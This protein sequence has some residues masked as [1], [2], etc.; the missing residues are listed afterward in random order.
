[1]RVSWILK[2]LAMLLFV[3]ST[4]RNLLRIWCN[5][6]QK[7]CY[8][9]YIDPTWHLALWVHAPSWM[10]SRLSQVCILCSIP[11]IVLWIQ[12]WWTCQ[13]P[14][15]WST[16]KDWGR[17]SS[18]RCV[19]KRSIRPQNVTWWIELIT[20]PLHSLD[21]SSLSCSSRTRKTE[22]RLIHSSACKKSFLYIANQVGVIVVR[23]SYANIL[24]NGR[25]G[26]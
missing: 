18:I 16:S 7:L 25:W 8:D 1:M 13:M 21:Y 4:V 24:I 6:P 19:Q 15:R 20:E 9:L 3:V 12:S 22:K 14:L 2:F 17:W 26:V 23:K 5:T 11:I 10:I